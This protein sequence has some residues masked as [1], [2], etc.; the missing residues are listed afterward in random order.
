MTYRYHRSNQILSKSF[1]ATK[2]IQTIRAALP[3]Y[4]FFSETNG[5]ASS[6]HFR[7]TSTPHPL[8]T[9]D[10]SLKAKPSTH[11]PS[12]SDISKDARREVKGEE[13]VSLQYHHSSHLVYHYISVS[14]IIWLQPLGHVLGDHTGLQQNHIW[15]E[16]ELKEKLTTPYHHQPQTMSDHAVRI[17]VR[18]RH[19]VN[20]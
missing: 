7:R 12:G 6:V 19:L 17:V 20:I 13:K 10:N 5:E 18:D 16:D 14:M 8:A 9:K 4:R 11:S 1:V 2:N 15:T 3:S